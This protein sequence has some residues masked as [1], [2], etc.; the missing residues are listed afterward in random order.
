MRPSRES[1]REIIRKSAQDRLRSFIGQVD[2]GNVQATAE[3][4]AERAEEMVREL[5]DV[6]NVKVVV[7][8]MS[9]DERIVR[10][11]MEE[12]DDSVRLEITLKPAPV[13]HFHAVFNFGKNSEGA[14]WVSEERPPVDEDVAPCPVPSPE[15]DDT[16]DVS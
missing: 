2:D 16:P 8:E 7:R 3:Y 4:V 1:I 15:S 11:V 10:E 9:E 14:I 13:T 5:S 6:E 12:P